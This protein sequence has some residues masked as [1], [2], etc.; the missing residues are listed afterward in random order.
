ML[1]KMS[2]HIEQHGSIVQRYF[3]ILILHVNIQEPCS[4]CVYVASALN[5]FK[6]KQSN[7]Q[8]THYSLEWYEDHLEFPEN[9]QDKDILIVVRWNCKPQKKRKSGT[10]WMMSNGS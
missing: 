2:N 7:Q 8:I 4:Y 10:T 3:S 1:F 9:S 5:F 6:G